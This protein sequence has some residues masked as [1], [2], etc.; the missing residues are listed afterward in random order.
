M[1]HATESRVHVLVMWLK[2]VTK[3]GPQHA[4]GGTRRAA[5]HDEVFPI[6]EIRRV[7]AVERKWFETGERRELARGPFPSIS[8]EVVYAESA[9]P[10]RKRI[11]RHRIPTMKI[12]IAQS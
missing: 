12:E 2:P 1:T 7:A 8:H 11:H 5:L 3:C 10:L 4:R 6:E 9:L